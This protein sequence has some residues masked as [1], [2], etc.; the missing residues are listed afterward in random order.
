MTKVP[1]PPL[2]EPSPSRF[3]LPKEC[4][5]VF[6]HIYS[7][8]KTPDSATRAALAAQFNVTPRQVQVWFQNKRQPSAALRATAPPPSAPT[9]SAHSMPSEPSLSCSERFQ[10]QHLIAPHAEQREHISF[11]NRRNGSTDSLADLA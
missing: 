8:E 3:R 6:E 4:K 9:P 1:S 7:V 5:A 11:S 10:F 2:D